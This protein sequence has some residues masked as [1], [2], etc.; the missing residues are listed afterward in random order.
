[1][2]ILCWL[3]ANI[4]TVIV[5]LAIAAIVGVIIARMVINKR[6]GVSSCGCGCSQ[7]GMCNR[8]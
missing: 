8:K 5:A 3:G 2:S 4:G 6:R 7:C 1:M